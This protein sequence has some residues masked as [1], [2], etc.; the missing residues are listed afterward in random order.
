VAAVGSNDV[1]PITVSAAFTVPGIPV[2]STG[3]LPA[4]LNSTP[5]GLILMLVG[6]AVVMIALGFRLRRPAEH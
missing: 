2:P 4:S 5:M 1:F 3:A 6:A